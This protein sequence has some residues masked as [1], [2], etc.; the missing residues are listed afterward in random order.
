MGDRWSRGWGSYVQP[1]GGLEGRR[2]E[3]GGGVALPCP[4]PP[5][6]SQATP[7]HT[8][9]YPANITHPASYS[10]RPPGQRQHSPAGKGQCKL[11]PGPSPMGHLLSRPFQAL[12]PGTLTWALWLAGAFSKAVL[13]PSNLQ[14]P[15]SVCP[16]EPGRGGGCSLHPGAALVPQTCLVTLLGSR[17][18]AELPGAPAWR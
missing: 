1:W 11:H 16:W 6:A 10:L 8:T 4:P 9:P 5:W 7:P 18:P 15:F 13:R 3:P 17:F 2:L 12:S 14:I